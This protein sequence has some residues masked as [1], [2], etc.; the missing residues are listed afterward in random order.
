MGF[1][2]MLSNSYYCIKMHEHL[3]IAYNNVTCFDVY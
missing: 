2:I 1:V 3:L